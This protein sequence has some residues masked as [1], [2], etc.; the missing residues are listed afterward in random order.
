MANRRMF[1]A[2]VTESTRFLK[3][4]ATS[5][6]LY[7]HLGMRADDDGVVEAYPIMRMLG[8]NE[9]DLRVL[10]SK[11]F[12]TILN[13]DYVTFLNDWLECNSIRADRKV[14][15]IYKDLL[16][17][18]VPDAEIR[19]ARESYYS[20]KKLIC[21]TNDGQMTDDCQAN[22]SLGKDRLSK[23]RL[24]K[25][26]NMVNDVDRICTLLN[27]AK[28]KAGS[29]GR[30]KAKGAEWHIEEILNAGVSMD[31]IIAAAENAAQSGKDV[32]WYSFKAMLIDSEK[33]GI[34]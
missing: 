12:A 26:N 14:D 4:P 6:N 30:L 21:Q 29:R 17:Q 28:A 5:Q 20:R 15:S 1:S 31:A 27:Q 22:D 8:A 32:D 7:F 18:V 16:L 23:G 24:D 19:S 34:S 2:R 11:G 10:V 9:D 33:G 13:A 25:K 3:M